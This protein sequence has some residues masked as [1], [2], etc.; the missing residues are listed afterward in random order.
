MRL[1]CGALLALALAGGADAQTLSLPGGQLYRPG[2]DFASDVLQDAWDFS[3]PEDV[4]PDA[5][6]MLGWVSPTPDTVRTVGT[7]ATF[8]SGGRFRGVPGVDS[9]VTLLYRADANALN[10]GR[11]GISAPIDPARYRKLAVKMRVTGAPVQEQLVAYWFHRSLLEGDWLNSGAA[12]GAPLLVP[13]GDSEQIYVV[14]LATA[15]SLY[16][17]CGGPGCTGVPMPYTASSTIRGLRLDP[18]NGAAGGVE[19]DWVR[20]TAG[21]GQ[22]SSAMMPVALAGCSAFESLLV[23]ETATGVSTRILDSTGTNASRS[24]NYGI[25]PPGAYTVRAT[26]SNGMTPAVAFQI[27][28]PPVVTVTDPDERGDPSTDYALLAR[29][30]DAW[31]FEQLADVAR[32]FNVATTGG[33]CAS[34][35][36]GIVPTERPGGTG[37]MLRFTSANAVGDPGLEFL[38]GP[39]VPLNSRRHRLLTFSMRHRRPYV[40]NPAIG[41]VLRVLWSFEEIPGGF[42]FTHSQDMRV[43][44]GFHTYTI[45]MA[46]LTTTNGGIETECTSCPTAP[47]TTRSVRHLRIDPHEYGDA[48]TATEIDD[49]TLTAPDEV[50]LGQQFTIRYGFTDANSTGSTYSARIVLEHWPSRTGRIVVATLPNITPGARTYVFNPQA[51]GVAAGEYAVVVEIDEAKAGVPQVVTSRGYGSGMLVVSN[52][53]A[54]STQVTVATP[55][56]GATLPQA[57]TIEGCAFDAG[58]TTGGLNVDDLV[59]TAVAGAGVAGLSQGTTIALGGG[60]MRGTTRFAPLGSVV[61]CPSVSDPASPYRN[62]GFLVEN[63]ALEPGPWTIRVAARSTLSGAFQATD[64]PVTIGNVLSPPINF[65]AAASGN[66]VTVSWLA[67]AGGPAI[68]GYVLDV[69]TNP[70]FAPLAHRLV[71][72]AAGA[73]SGAL[74]SG[75]Y[76]FRVSSAAATGAQSA[77]SAPRMVDVNLP[78][79]PGAPVL[80][81]TQPTPSQVAL[82]WTPGPGGAPLGYTLYVGS[83]PGGSDLGVFPVG[84]TTSLVGP[85]LPGTF[86]VRVVASNAAGSAASNDVRVPVEA[87]GTPTMHVPGVH[88]GVVTLSWSPGATGGIPTGYLLRVRVPG[89]ALLMSAPVSGTSLTAPAPPGTYHVS[90]VA[91]GALG[92]SAESNSVTVVVP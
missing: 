20:L 53:G 16:P 14:D 26:C 87:P 21:D 57:F 5:D 77:P 63:V 56:A 17:A 62:A 83:T 13:P 81:V 79:A 54:T 59:V 71:V 42:N 10:P 29:G 74:P 27:D 2:P 43:W 60:G 75:R 78:Q 33:A 22:A 61:T 52:P 30:G 76:Y 48:P 35:P 49:V 68:A 69:A 73:Y 45:D 28:A 41:A 3:N 90:V 23:T 65:Q 72:P 44:P 37:Q 55:G 39:A 66:L 11:S 50:A 82:A 89:G 12:A 24:F 32:T 85:A 86:Y 46:A 15:P 51:A 36:C 84:L 9:N 8:I 92:M 6:Q 58:T 64:V 34:L 88:D 91:V 67:P 25:L 31:D 19:I 38:N 1:A 70:S 4:A 7:G 40:L 47:W 18:I 80:T